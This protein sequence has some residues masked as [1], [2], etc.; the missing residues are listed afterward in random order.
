MTAEQNVDPDIRRFLD[1]MAADWR[2]FPPLDSL[3]HAEARLAAEQVRARWAAGGPAME[4]TRDHDIATAVGPIRV[5][6]YRPAGLAAGPAPAMV[7]VHGGGFTLFSID[8]HDRLMREYAEAGGFAVIGVDY[9]LSPEAKFPV[10][11]DRITA[12]LLWLEVHAA[13][14][15]IDPGRLALGGDSAGGNL[16]V[17][18]CLR[19]RD[20]GKLGIVQAVL[21]NYGGF[22]GRCSDLSEALYG[23]P[24]SVLSRSEAEQ[25]WRNYLNGPAELEN[26]YANPLNA[27]LSGLPPVFLVIPELD[28]VAEHS[29]A[30]EVLLDRAGVTV[31]SK[32]YR[33][34]THSFLEAMS[35]SALAR[36]A[37]A[38]G[39]AFVR[40]RLY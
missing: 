32:V 25:Y 24:G 38:D 35:I 39:A 12:L 30:M 1:I 28:L 3:S 27:D 14:L 36:E 20:G 18:A 10:A 34:A 26:P 29:Y 7:Y 19:L 21:S 22:S 2:Q 11:L 9:P 31:H 5:R 8:T 17:A 6:V 16:S 37:I 33:G 23:G 15:G 40:E 4:E 13:T